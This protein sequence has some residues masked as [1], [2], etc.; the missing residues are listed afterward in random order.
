[1]PKKQK[2]EEV[3]LFVKLA[4]KLKAALFAYADERDLSASQVVRRIIT[5]HLDEKKEVES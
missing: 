3:V 4:P 1:M 5:A 2:D